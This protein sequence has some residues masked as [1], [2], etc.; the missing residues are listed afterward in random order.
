MLHSYVHEGIEVHELTDSMWYDLY[1]HSFRH[2]EIT[3]ESDKNWLCVDEYTG[4]DWIVVFSLCA[5]DSILGVVH[6][7]FSDESLEDVVEYVLDNFGTELEQG[8]EPYGYIDAVEIWH[9]VDDSCMQEHYPAEP[10][11]ISEHIMCKRVEDRVK[12]DVR[13]AIYDEMKSYI[14][15][16]VRPL[17]YTLDVLEMIGERVGVN[18]RY[19]LRADSHLIDRVSVTYEGSSKARLLI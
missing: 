6:V 16:D 1:K 2:C 17:Y 9:R 19:W 7:D 5:F 13:D 11:T 14:G 12:T 4:E 8:R 18:V 15:K 3:A 10:E